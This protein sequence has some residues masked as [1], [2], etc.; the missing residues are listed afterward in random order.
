MSNKKCEP[1]HEFWDDRWEAYRDFFQLIIVRYLIIWFSVVPVVAGIVS[2]LPSPLVIEFANVT[3]EIELI[4]PFN[5]QL[6]WL[7]SLFF[8]FALAIYKIFCPKFIQEYNNFT[9]Y[10]SFGHHPRWLVWQA[11]K[12]L[13]KL[14]N[15]N[16][17]KFFKRL[18]DKGYLEEVKRK[19]LAELCKKPIVAKKETFIVFKV[20][21]IAYRFGMPTNKV[22]QE[23]EPE[24]DVFYEIFGRYSQSKKPAR[25]TIKLFLLVSLVLFLIVVGQHVWNGSLFV[26]D[27]AQGFI[28]EAV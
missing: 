26:W 2:Q 25:V 23:N 14:D 21:G 17:E 28:N 19:G 10:N 13:K 4:M 3:H 24:K 9:D 12:L 7:S 20:S 11:H 27:W 18:W 16:K 8:V 5:W 6:M 22:D 15:C 1:W